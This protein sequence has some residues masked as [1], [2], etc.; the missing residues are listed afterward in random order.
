[1][2][3]RSRPSASNVPSSCMLLSVHAWRRKPVLIF[4]EPGLE[5]DNLAA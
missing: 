2:A 5:K 1:M 4:G 3:E